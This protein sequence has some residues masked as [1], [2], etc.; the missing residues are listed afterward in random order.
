MR[1]SSKG[2]W[3]DQVQFGVFVRVPTRF[4][5]MIEVI[6]FLKF[7]KYVVQVNN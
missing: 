3:F 5:T 6:H 7:I 1:G 4:I 2:I